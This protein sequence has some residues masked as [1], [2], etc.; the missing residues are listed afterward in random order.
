MT[1]ISEV[2]K[3]VV[4]RRA[5]RKRGLA[6]KEAHRAP[7]DERLDWEAACYRWSIVDAVSGRVILEKV[8]I[9]YFARSIGVLNYWESDDFPI[10]APAF[11]SSRMGNDEMDKTTP[12][13]DASD[14]GIGAR[15]PNQNMPAMRAYAQQIK[16]PQTMPGRS[17][18]EPKTNSVG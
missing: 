15:R 6:L 9:S 5:L 18:S 2:S 1:I 7:A 4:L 8:D 14:S 17:G 11:R 3:E 13:T 10:K 12:C 16:N